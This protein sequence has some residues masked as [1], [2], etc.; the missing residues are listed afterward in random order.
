MASVE[1][2][3]KYDQPVGSALTPASWTDQVIVLVVPGLN[4]GSGTRVS[5]ADNTTGTTGTVGSSLRQPARASSSRKATTALAIVLYLCVVD[6]IN[7]FSRTNHRRDPVSTS[8]GRFIRFGHQSA[9]AA[10]GSSRW[11]VSRVSHDG[12]EMRHFKGTHC[13]LMA[14]SGAKGKCANMV[15]LLLINCVIRFMEIMVLSMHDNESILQIWLFERGAGLQGGEA[16]RANPAS[17][18]TQTR[19]R[20]RARAS[21]G[22]FI[23]SSIFSVDFTLSHSSGG[24][25]D[26][27]PA[28][29]S[30][31]FMTKLGNQK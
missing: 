17:S 22:F 14:M 20:L 18:H 9:S 28:L 16:G 31:P 12:S 27:A 19:R 4:S 30:D 25:R 8:L 1:L 24:P 5:P 23:T 21:P 7:L 11:L 13:R 6:M 26:I 3:A 10:V 15:I 2:C 29:I